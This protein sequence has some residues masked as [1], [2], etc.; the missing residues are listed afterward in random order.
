MTYSI[1]A[2]DSQTGE[3]GVAVQSH[4]LSV[5]S[6]VPWAASGVGAVATQS[7]ALASYGPLGLDLMRAG[8]AAPDALRALVTADGDQDR[9]QVAMVD[10]AGRVGT[11]TGSRCIPE[12]GDVQGDGF[13]AQA[14]MMR[15]PGV[16][17]AMAGAFTSASGS[18]PLRLLAALDAAEAAG[19][20]IR[21]R[22]SAAIL[23]VGGEPT[24][25]AWNDV[26]VEMRVED[27]PEPLAELRRL[28]ALR[29]AYNA[30]GDDPITPALDD[31]NLQFGAV[32]ACAAAGRIDDAA[33]F[34]ANLRAVHDGWD[35]LLRRLPAVGLLPDDPEVL[36][37]ILGND[38]VR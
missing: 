33:R 35:E 5:G 9:R 20:D 34:A 21:G 27:H 15:D 28:V 19:G 29:L 2:R 32:L 14:N 30:A 23:V 25:Q 36:E 16:P 10:A 26:V 31:R 24:G 13:S 18:L 6:I 37:Q 1:V 12:A 7:F 11:H 3:F 38:A 8:I 17:E 22:Q 4:Y